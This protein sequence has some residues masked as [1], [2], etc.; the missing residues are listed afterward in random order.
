MKKI[1]I[2]LML[3]I[4]G[5][6]IAK[7][8]EWQAPQK[9]EPKRTYLYQAVI[10]Q[11][12]DTTLFNTSQ[13]YAAFNLA[14]KLSGRM[15]MISPQEFQKAMQKF[16]GKDFTNDTLF[17]ELNLYKLYI[18]KVEALLNVIR[19]EVISSDA[20]AQI[21]TGDGYALLHLFKSNGPVIDPTALLALQRAMCVAENNT[22]LYAHQT[23]P[24]NP[25]PVPCLAICGI[26]FQNISQNWEI[27]KEQVV[28]SYE[29]CEII[30]EEIYKTNNF[31][32]YDI[33]SRDA[34]YAMFNLYGTENNVPPSKN[35]IAALDSFNVQYFITG[36]LEEISENK[37][38]P[39]KS[40]LKITLYLNQIQNHIIKTLRSEEAIIAQDDAKFLREQL[41]LIAKKLIPN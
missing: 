1:L 9:L 11:G 26:E 37:N 19:V 21:T 16:E 10:G 24:Y 27:M 13:L 32:V 31:M 39:K 30:F 23:E 35:E 6:N 36:K 17:L 15:E 34:V 22:N 5:S 3:I 7:S 25:K 38:N 14:C 18:I 28:K 12:I 29:L 20:N 4:F 40:V 33:A 8:Q 41:K 2:L